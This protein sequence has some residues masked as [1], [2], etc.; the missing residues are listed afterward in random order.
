MPASTKWMSVWPSRIWSG[1]HGCIG[2]LG[3]GCSL[4]HSQLRSLC[5]AQANKGL[6]SR[7][8]DWR[9]VIRRIIRS[10]CPPAILSRET[11]FAPAAP[12]VLCRMRVAGFRGDSRRR[13]RSLRAFQQALGQEQLDALERDAVAGVAAVIGLGDV[14]LFVNQEIRRHQVGG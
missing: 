5:A 6:S 11:G 4:V 7:K 8:A 10:W 1:C 13:G 2:R 14:T 12:A 9:S 3:S